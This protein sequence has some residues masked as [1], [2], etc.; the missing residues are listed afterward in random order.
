MANLTSLIVNDTGFL[1]LPSGT[2][3]QRP[4]ATAGRLR[5]NTSKGELEINNGTVWK[6]AQISEPSIVTNGLVLHLDAG[7]VS[8]YPGTGTVWSDVSGNSNNGTLTNGPTYNSGNG[9]S[10][11]FDGTNDYVVTPSNVNLSDTDKISVCLWTKISSTSIYVLFEHST[12]FNSNNAFFVDINEVNGIGA[13]CF[14]DHNPGYNI[15]YTSNG[16]NDGK[17]HYFCATSDRSLGSTNQINLYVDGIYNKI[18]HASYTVDLTGNYSTFPAYISSRGGS[19]YFLNGNVSN[20]QLYN[21]A[22]TAAEI[23]QNFEALRGRYS[24]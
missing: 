6:S 7:N 2:A 22:L 5:Y 9:G 18:Q 19:S 1:K 14:G 10:I 8:S 20:V 11:V 17:W 13:Y 12:N 15:A 21:R 24:A 3:D 16:Y 4:A 23:Q